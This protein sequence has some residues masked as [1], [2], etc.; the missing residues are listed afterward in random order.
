MSL[1]NASMVPFSSASRPSSRVFTATTVPFTSLAFSAACSAR[2]FVVFAITPILLPARSLNVF[3][4]DSFRTS[5]PVE[6]TK[7]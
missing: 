5:T 7:M 6:S 3:T 2:S 4:P 1:A